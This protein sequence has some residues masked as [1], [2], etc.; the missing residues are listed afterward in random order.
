MLFR[1]QALHSH[2]TTVKIGK[3]TYAVVEGPD[4]FEPGGG[5]RRER[6]LTCVSTDP[7]EP[8]WSHPL[9]SV[10]IPIPLPS[11]PPARP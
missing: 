8:G 1:S 4:K 11:A 10:Q 2:V 7:A 3:R 5:L 6:R 9:R